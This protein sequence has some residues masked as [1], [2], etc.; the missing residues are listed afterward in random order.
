[1]FFIK[2]SFLLPLVQIKTLKDLLCPPASPQNF[3][4]ANS[5]PHTLLS[6][7]VLA[8][9]II[10]NAIHFIFAPSKAK[11]RSSGSAPWLSFS[12]NI[13]DDNTRLYESKPVSAFSIHPGLNKCIGLS[14]Y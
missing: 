8:L 1:M 14:S 4:S 2:M 13:A 11:G 3:S 9:Q 6:R 5:L 12:K 10:K 7:A